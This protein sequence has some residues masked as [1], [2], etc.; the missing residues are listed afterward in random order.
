MFKD[1]HSLFLFLEEKANF[2]NRPHFIEA[3][4][5]SIPHRFRS[6]A[7]KEISGFFAA[8]LAWGNRKTIISKCLELLERMDNCPHQFILDSQP[9]DLRALIGFKHRT[10][11]DTDLLYFVEFLRHHF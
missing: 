6:N 10:F 3:D 9:S 5:V 8:V 11:N 4:P 7:D 1:Q 2:Y